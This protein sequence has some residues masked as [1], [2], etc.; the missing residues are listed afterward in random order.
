MKKPMYK[1]N[2][3]IIA[4]CLIIVIMGIGY[5]AFSSL[6]TI[7]GTANILNSWCVGFDNTKTDTYQITKGLSIGTTPTGSMSYSGTVCGT[8]LVP[9]ASLA[10]HFYQPGDQ[11]EYTLTI[12]NA[13][14]VPVAIKS[15]LIDN[16]SVTSNTAITKGNIQ[17]IVNMPAST[18]I[19]VNG[20]TTMKVIAKFQNDTDVTGAYAGSETQTIQ[21]KINAEQGNG[22]DGFTPTAAEYTGTIYRWSTTRL[23]N[24]DSSSA[25]TYPYIITNLTEGTD[26]VKNASLLNKNYYLKHDIV[27]DEII[28]SYV[29]FVYNNAEHCMKGGDGGASFA[30]N[31]QI[32]RDFQ[33]FNNLP[34]NSNPGCYYNSSSSYCFGGGFY[35]ESIGSNGSAYVFGT[36]SENCGINDSGYSVCSE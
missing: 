24:K 21:V 12:Q 22:S 3:I 29:C 26:Y 33:T 6:L 23:A 28:N 25:S 14:T 36:S 9:T 2:Y 30:A 5:A 16:Q 35:D 34:D 18:N 1:S 11:I 20:T 17:Y 15:I 8:N 4:L 10:S 13:S 7:N 32:I 19:A 31:T 27:D